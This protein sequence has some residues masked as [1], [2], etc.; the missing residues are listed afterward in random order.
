MLLLT[1]CGVPKTEYEGLESEISIL[2]NEL[3][4]LMEKTLDYEKTNAQLTEKLLRSEEL[5]QD[6]TLEKNTLQT[7]KTDLSER[8]KMLEELINQAEKKLTESNNESNNP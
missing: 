3:D 4:R 5:I 6:M 8:V 1:S 7:E 2:E